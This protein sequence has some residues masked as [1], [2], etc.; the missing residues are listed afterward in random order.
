LTAEP[1]RRNTRMNTVHLVGMT[2]GA[3]ND[4]GSRTFFTVSVPRPVKPGSKQT[5][6][7][8][9][10]VAQGKSRREMPVPFP[11]HKSVWISGRLRKES[12]EMVVA[13][14]DFVL[15]S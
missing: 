3:C 8:I 12:G 14:H 1:E 6:D 9:D 7:F 13:V 10:C 15:T 5:F 2:T 11:A 4:T